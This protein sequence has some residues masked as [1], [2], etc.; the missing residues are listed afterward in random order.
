MLKSTY[1][2]ITLFLL[3]QIG[4]S[5]DYLNEAQKWVDRVYTQIVTVGCKHGSPP[6]KKYDEIKQK[7]Q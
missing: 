2:T 4:E 6:A 1:F 7:K 3:I 5:I